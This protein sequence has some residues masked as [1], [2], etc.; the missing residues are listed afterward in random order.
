MEEN[1]NNGLAIAGFVV[2]LVSLF[3][4]FAGIVG[5]IATILSAVG[6]A[7]SKELNGKGKGLAIAGL[8]IGIIGIVYGIYSIFKAAALLSS[9]GL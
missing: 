4:N 9:I 8:I 3:I 7:K 6:L 1:K 5:L 2:S